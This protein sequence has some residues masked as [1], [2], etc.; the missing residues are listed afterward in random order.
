MPQFLEA[1]VRATWRLF[2][3][4]GYYLQVRCIPGNANGLLINNENE[5]VRWAREHNGKGNLFVGRNPRSLDGEANMIRCVSFDLDPV[6]GGTSDDCLRASNDFVSH[7]PGGVIGFSGRGYHVYYVASDPIT[8]D[9]RSFERAYGKF[10]EYVSQTVLK[11]H[12]GVKL[13]DLHDTARLDRILGAVSTK[14][15]GGLTRFLSLPGRSCNGDGIFNR[16]K[17]IGG[18]VSG[19]EGG[20]LAQPNGGNFRPDGLAAPIL[21]Q[22]RGLRVGYSSTEDG[23]QLVPHGARSNYLARIAGALRRQGLEHEA[24]FQALKAAYDTKCAHLP[25]EQESVYED[26]RRMARGFERYE[27]AKIDYRNISGPNN[28][29]SNNLGGVVDVSVA[30]PSDTLDAYESLLKKRAE[31]KEPKYPTGFP[32]ID[33]KTEGFTEGDL[34]VVGANTGA[35]KSTWCVN[36]ADSLLKRGTKVLLL[37]TE[38]TRY[39]IYDKVFSLNTG[40][41][42]KKFRR[43]DFTASERAAVDEF[44]ARF[45]DYQ[46]VINDLLSPS[47]EQVREMVKREKPEVLFLD[48]I[49]QVGSG[50]TNLYGFL[51]K[52]TNELK[53]L[54]ESFKI[55]VVVAAQFSRPERMMDK[56][57]GDVKIARKP[58]VYD[59]KACGEIENRAATA[60]LLYDTKESVDLN[61]NKVGADIAKCRHGERGFVEIAWKWRTNVMQEVG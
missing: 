55:P 46:L 34:F 9:L 35:G 41:E 8:T 33:D 47:I 59:F 17:E 5:F 43:G 61:V 26:L 20:V 28:Q 4:G 50:S 2:S 54:S 60:L 7:F 27:P 36:A 13:D 37:S 38:L 11:N 39:Q 48:H 21:D 49:H 19:A 29:L 24:I 56:E 16:I 6:N 23:G 40:I 25:G 44:K 53:D 58:T 30:T 32:S 31:H 14:A 51:S 42:Y 22:E 18:N 3:L 12:A 1:H 45:K 57:T 15:G 52:F 10:N